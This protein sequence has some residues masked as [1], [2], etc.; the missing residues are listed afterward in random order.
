MD[1]DRAPYN[2][3][4]LLSNIGGL[5]VGQCR[6]KHVHFSLQIADDVPAAIMG[7]AL[8]VRQ[9]LTNLLATNVVKFTPS[10]SITLTAACA[11]HSRIPSSNPG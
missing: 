2:F 9:V 8:R 11:P 1:I 6:S 5:F 10:G 7:D 3:R 4:T